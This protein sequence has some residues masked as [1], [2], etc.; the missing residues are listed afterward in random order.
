MFHS[1]FFYRSRDGQR[2]STCIGPK[3]TVFFAFCYLFYLFTGQTHFL[4]VTPYGPLFFTQNAVANYLNS[5]TVFKSTQ[6]SEC[7]NRRKFLT[8]IISPSNKYN[9]NVDMLQNCY[10][11][12]YQC[13][14]PLPVSRTSISVKNLYQCQEPLS[15]SRT[16]ISVKNLYQC[17][18]PLS[19]SRTSISVKNLYQCQEPLQV[20][21]TSISVNNLYQC[22]ELLSVS[23]TSISVKNLYQCQEPLSVSR[24]SISVKNLYKCQ[25]PL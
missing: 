10:K 13:Q 21:R 14:E 18:E 17:Q 8:I 20:S 24:T 7:R 15:V 5:E 6:Y 2:Q 11:N 16:S 25:G 12:L 23:R 19:V 22:Q 1:I 3:N 9:T 4:P